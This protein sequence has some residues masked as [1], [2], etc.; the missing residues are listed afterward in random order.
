MKQIIDKELEIKEILNTVLQA[1]E[2]FKRANTDDEGKKK[3]EQNSNAIY[4]NA[5]KAL[6]VP[7]ALVQCGGGGASE[8]YKRFETGSWF[9]NRI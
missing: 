7:F 1:K 2:Q 9:R 6:V 5:I 3:A 4:A 8:I